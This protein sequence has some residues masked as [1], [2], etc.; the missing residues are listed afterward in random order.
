MNDKYQTAEERIKQKSRELGFLDCGIS[1][2]DFL[3]DEKDH[4]TNWLSLGFQAGMVYMARNLE[5]RLDPRLLV[6]NARS[7]ISVLYNYYPSTTQSDP[8]A[9]VISKYAY[10]T[11]YHF[12]LK[13]KLSL[14]LNFIRDEIAPCE[15]RAF[16]D[17]AP[18][19]D[20]AWAAR[21]GLGGVAKTPI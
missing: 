12:V 20:R 1:Q 11:D 17:S 14:L 15:G 3:S 16:V 8:K 6:E 4:L 19:L 7:V 5:K 2:A 13:E 21:A 9:P 10:G 18:V